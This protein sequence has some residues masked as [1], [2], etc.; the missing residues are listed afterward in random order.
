MLIE[1]KALIPHPLEHRLSL[2][3]V[4]RYRDRRASTRLLSS[5]QIVPVF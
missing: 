2:R 3:V 4:E 5:S 1:L